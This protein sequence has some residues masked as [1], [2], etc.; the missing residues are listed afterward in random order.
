MVPLPIRDHNPTQRPPVVT[1]TLILVCVVAWVFQLMAGVETAVLDYGAIPAWVLHGVRQGRLFLQG[2]GWVEL[3]Q[4]VPAPL[5]V[6]T[7]MFL[8]GGWLHLIG[9]L[10]FLWIFGDNVEDRMGRVRFLVFYLLCG[11]LAAMAQI[12]STPSS[13]VPIV[14]ASGAIAGVLGGY[15]M[16]FPHA[17]IHCLWVLIIF[18]T[19][20]EVPAWVLLGLWF[21]SQFLIPDNS[22]IAW[23]AH[24]GG[25]VAGL[26]LVRLFTAG[27]RRQEGPSRWQRHRHG[28]SGPSSWTN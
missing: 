26:L 14:G 17:R 12:L 6:L 15:I 18:I 9:N 5:T 2:Y 16:L 25:F 7:S 10:W 22:G 28:P 13:T 21:L 4:E 11:G 20:V 27:A 24:V 1:I 23:Q 8:H 3:Y 19:T